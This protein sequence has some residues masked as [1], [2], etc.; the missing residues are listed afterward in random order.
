MRQS[1]IRRSLDDLLRCPLG[2]WVCGDVEV[3]DLTAVVAK[4][5]KRKQNPERS[6]RNGKDVN[7][8]DVLD[9][10]IEERAPGLC[11]RLLGTD[12]ILVD[13][14]IGDNIP[15]QRELGLNPWSSADWILA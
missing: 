10:V 8:Y 13:R 3:H 2:C 6:G 5:D 9:V 15:E 12:S 7:G 11:W 1:L 4:H 14:G